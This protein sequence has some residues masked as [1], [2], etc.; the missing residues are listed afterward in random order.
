MRGEDEHFFPVLF[1]KAALLYDRL[2]QAQGLHLRVSGTGWPGDG[3]GPGVWTGG[4]LVVTV[5]SSDGRI[6][7]GG[8]DALNRSG[9]NGKNLK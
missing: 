7:R 2:G 3:F 6:E 9:Y 4:G 5:L 1:Y 8:D